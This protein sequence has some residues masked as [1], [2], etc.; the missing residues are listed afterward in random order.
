MIS[1]SYRL[2]YILDGAWRRRYT[3]VLPIL[4]LPLIGLLVGISTPKQYADK[5]Q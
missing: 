5:G 4:L 1:L 2:Y 3:I